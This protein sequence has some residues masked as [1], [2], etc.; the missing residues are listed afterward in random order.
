MMDN[1]LS[2]L[3]KG[4]IFVGDGAMGTQLMFKGLKSGE[5]PEKLCLNNPEILEEISV[6]YLNA[7]AD[8]IQTNTFGGSPVKLKEYY[9]DKETEEINKTAAAIVKRAVQGKAYVSGS[10]GP[11]GQLLEPF[12]PAGPKGLYDGFKRQISALIDGGVDIICVETM[13]DLNEATLAV[14]AAKDISADI[15]VMATMTFN[16]TPRGYFTMMG[17]NIGNAVHGLTDAGAD[18]IG[19]NCGNGIDNMVEIC[20]EFKSLTDKPIIIQSNA[21]LPE[22]RGNELVYPESAEY[23]GE[24]ARIMLEKGVSIIGGC[25]GTT[26]D[27]I[28]ELRKT[29]NQY[30]KK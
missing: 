9:L 1:L 13:I 21:G 29:V 7:G 3:K 8:I 22:L 14:K 19:S 28:K 12:G 24:K 27:H 30:Q 26:P 15:I 6:N 11:S 20:E 17:I 23:F 25:C 18:I 5:C 2:R 10:C 16:K 4:Q